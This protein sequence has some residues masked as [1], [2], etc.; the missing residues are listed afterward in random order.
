VTT[1]TAPVFIEEALARSD[2]K[3]TNA[4]RKPWWQMARTPRQGLVL[5]IC[6]ILLGLGFLSPG[7]VAG[8]SL[9]VAASVLYMTMGAA[10][11]VSATALFRY[12]RSHPQPISA[13]KTHES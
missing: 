5:G 13:R 8:L 4:R 11:L 7:L 3:V 1:T 2:G 6:C 10:Q 9:W 12:K